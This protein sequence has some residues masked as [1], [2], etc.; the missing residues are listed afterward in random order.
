MIT[1]DKRGTV[2]DRMSGVPSLEER[3]DDVRAVMDAVGSS[4][5]ALLGV[6]E[7][8]AW[9]LI[10]NRPLL[11]RSSCHTARREPEWAVRGASLVAT[12]ESS[13]SRSIVRH[14]HDV[15]PPVNGLRVRRA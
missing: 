14:N 2:S 15:D 7:G 4:R 12:Q 11:E 9:T 1:F 6:N 10:P 8:G 13:A 3:M 5:A